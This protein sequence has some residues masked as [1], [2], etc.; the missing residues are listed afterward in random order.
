MAV[1]R[2]LLGKD[3]VMMIMA[4]PRWTWVLCKVPTERKQPKEQET[5]P[6]GSAMKKVIFVE[7]AQNAGEMA[8]PS[9]IKA[10]SFG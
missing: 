7:I 2:A 4:G 3:V 5:Q 6:A 1:A 9:G 8:K 10:I